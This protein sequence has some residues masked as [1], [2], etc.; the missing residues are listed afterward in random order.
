MEINYARTVFSIIQNTMSDVPKHTKVEE[1]KWVEPVMIVKRF[2]SRGI[3]WK[4]RFSPHQRFISSSTINGYLE[5]RNFVND[6]E[7]NAWKKKR[8]IVKVTK[9]YGDSASN[10][11]SGSK[12]Y[13]PY[14]SGYY[15]EYRY[16]HLLASNCQIILYYRQGKTVYN[17]E[18]IKC[19]ELSEKAKK[20]TKL[21][22]Y[23]ERQLEIKNSPLNLRSIKGSVTKSKT[24]E[25]CRTFSTNRSSRSAVGQSNQENM[26]V[27]LDFDLL[28]LA[29]FTE[30]LSLFLDEFAPLI[31]SLL[32]LYTKLL[33]DGSLKVSAQERLST[34]AEEDYKL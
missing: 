28:T 12:I 22:F 4:I 9:E 3:V 32:A 21:S 11:G 2:G 18:N 15:T 20:G 14:G 7:I 17:T 5:K 26:I 8:R 33:V 27:G 34:P 10:N 30:S 19:N 31:D 25:H 16:R 6:D 29:L 23:R 1:S 24:I 13:G